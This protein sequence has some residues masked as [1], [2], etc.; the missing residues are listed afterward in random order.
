MKLRQK[1]S[2]LRS[3]LIN[4]DI[5]L[6]FN[7]IAQLRRDEMALTRW[8]EAECN[9][10]IERD[11]NTGRPYRVT[12]FHSGPELRNV[13]PDRELSSLKRI[14]K[15]CEQNSIHFY[16][17]TDPRGCALY[18]STEP[19]ESNNYSTKGVAICD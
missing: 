5:N 4:R 6:D 1:I 7:T 18:L 3:R 17:Q 2:A 13:C 12:R 9:G 10:D 11:E 8:S 15:I 16:H 19:M 14:A